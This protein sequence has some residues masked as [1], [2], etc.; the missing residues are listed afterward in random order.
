MLRL[1]ERRR[2]ELRSL[3][4]AL[5]SGEAL[6]DGPRQ[7]L[8]RAGESLL[9]R[10]RSGLDA[11]AFRV[12]VLARGLARHSP[13]AHLAGLIERMRGLIGRFDRLPPVLIERPRRS[14]DAAGRSLA[15]E[16]IVLARRRAECAE[17]LARLEA[18]LERAFSEGARSRRAKLFGAAQML[19]AVSY[20]GVLER[21]FALV[22]DEA[23]M[24]LRRASV[25]QEGQRLR[26]EFADGEVFAAA[27]GGE[28]SPEARNP[29]PA[30]KP[31][32]AGRTRDG[33]GQ[34]SLF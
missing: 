14:A 11:R 12:S 19:E 33:E 3:V 1:S 26:I 10:L 32:R 13:R 20:R 8:D 15:R 31:K 2:A 34:G 22:R 24:P 9:G 27:K 21:G 6:L 7:R 28:P 5:P 16:R 29:A 17:A 25:V 23:R 18:R 30:T 4:R